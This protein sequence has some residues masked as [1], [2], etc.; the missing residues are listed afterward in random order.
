MIS[1]KLRPWTWYIPK[2]FAGIVSEFFVILGTTQQLVKAT[3]EANP[4]TKPV[5]N[6]CRIA[7]SALAYSHFLFPPIHTFTVTICTVLISMSCG[8][9]LRAAFMRTLQTPPSIGLIT[10]SLLPRKI[11]LFSL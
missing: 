9:L 11:R 4:L 7:P 8:V 6:S 3:S 5:L 2:R 1:C 10:V